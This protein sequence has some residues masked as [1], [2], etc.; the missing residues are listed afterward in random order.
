MNLVSK[1]PNQQKIE[2]KANLINFIVNYYEMSA[3][4]YTFYKDYTQKLSFFDSLG[5]SNNEV[6][7]CII[8]TETIS[9]DKVRDM[10]QEVIQEA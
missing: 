10:A 7:F 9:F 4:K 3:V 6:Q 1:N 2:F 5:L 8:D